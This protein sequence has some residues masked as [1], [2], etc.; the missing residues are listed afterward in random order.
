MEN[1][2]NGYWEAANGY[3]IPIAKIT[4]A[5]KARNNVVTSLCADAKTAFKSLNSFKESALDAVEEFV[6]ISANNFDTHLG[7]KKGNV[8]LV[9]FDGRLKVIRSM[10]EV[11]GFDEHIDEA[12]SSLKEIVNS[13]SADNDHLRDIVLTVCSR[14][15]NGNLNAANLIG[16]ANLEIHEDNWITAMNSVLNSVKIDVKPSIRFYE[17]DAAN[18]YQPIN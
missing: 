6:S 1:V 12:I 11:Y 5:D 18:E 3:L 2:P 8:T 16:L 7:G 9:S 4:E 14:D 17:R 13:W 10:Q 15:E